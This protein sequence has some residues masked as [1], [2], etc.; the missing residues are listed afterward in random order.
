MIITTLLRRAGLA[1]NIKL[2]GYYIM[3]DVGRNK[4][5]KTSSWNLMFKIKGS[6]P[7]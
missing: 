7:C 3:A 5:E 4:V 1:L 2:G 6:N